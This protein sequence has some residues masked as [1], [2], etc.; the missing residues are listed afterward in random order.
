MVQGLLPANTPSPQSAAGSLPTQILRH[1]SA[2]G[3]MEEDCTMSDG[4]LKDP[5][6]EGPI[7][8]GSGVWRHDGRGRPDGQEGSA[9]PF[10]TADLLCRL[11]GDRVLW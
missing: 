8:A 11:T 2:Y 5:L 1:R 9:R 10:M 4:Q 3:R 6:D 7:R